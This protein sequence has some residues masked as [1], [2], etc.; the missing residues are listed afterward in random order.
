MCIIWS[1]KCLILLMRGATMML[2]LIL[3]SG[4]KFRETL[5]EDLFSKERQNWPILSAI[6]R[7]SKSGFEGETIYLAGPA[8]CCFIPSFLRLRKSQGI[9]ANPS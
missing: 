1:I 3:Q 7:E 6:W 5:S 4:P 8:F 9:L 2:L